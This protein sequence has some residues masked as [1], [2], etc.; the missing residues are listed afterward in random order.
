MENY[1]NVKERF[2]KEANCPPEDFLPDEELIQVW[3]KAL[4]KKA[5]KSTLDN[6]TAEEIREEIEEVDGTISNERLWALADA[7]HWE[8]IAHLQAYRK[9]LE[10][11]LNN[12]T[13]KEA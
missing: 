1:K 13:R 4:L 2:E 9:E 10:C 7:I 11:L 3:L 12:K 6:L 5:G 8:N